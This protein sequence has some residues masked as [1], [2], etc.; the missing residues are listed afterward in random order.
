MPGAHSAGET[1]Q[2]PTRIPTLAEMLD[3]IEWASDGDKQ[4]VHDLLITRED[5]IVAFLHAT[6]AQFGLLPQVVAVALVEANLG[7]PMSQEEQALVR[8]NF[9]ALMEEVRRRQSGE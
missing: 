2:A 6:A 3:K 1:G 9:D 5:A 8:S 7:T 4:E